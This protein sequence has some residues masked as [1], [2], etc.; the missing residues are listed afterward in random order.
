MMLLTE[1]MACMECRAVW[2]QC[3]TI[4]II[5]GQPLSLLA[6]HS[7]RS[8][9]DPGLPQSQCQPP[10]PNFPLPG[11]PDEMLGM[12]SSSWWGK[13]KGLNPEPGIGS[14]C[15]GD[16]NHVKSSNPHAHNPKIRI[17]SQSQQLHVLP[18]PGGKTCNSLCLE[19]RY[20]TRIRSYHMIFFKYAS[21]KERR[22]KDWCSLNLCKVGLVFQYSRVYKKSH[23]PK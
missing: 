11:N 13:P 19:A 20:A 4:R 12:G 9:T 16:Q 14:S 17:C 15:A 18:L 22:R 2:G 21:Y 3:L 10:Y 1:C 7:P 23:T 5:S 8:P 6:W